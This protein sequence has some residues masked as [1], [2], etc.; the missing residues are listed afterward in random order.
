[1]TR[2]VTWRRG[3]GVQT[4][5]TLRGKHRRLDRRALSVEA[6]V[7]RMHEGARLHLHHDRQRGPVWRLSVIGVEVPDAIAQLVIQRSDIA[8]CGETLFAGCLGQT[9]RAIE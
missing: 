5:A 2:H 1:M 7:S 3:G 6:V 8:D 9:F 4:A